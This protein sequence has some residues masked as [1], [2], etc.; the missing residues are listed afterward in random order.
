MWKCLYFSTKVLNPNLMIFYQKSEYFKYSGS[1]E[2]RIY[3]IL[4]LLE[5]SATQHFSPDINYTGFV[6]NIIAKK[7]CA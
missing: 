6:I 4:G 7:N 1:I 5:K 3:L 2:R